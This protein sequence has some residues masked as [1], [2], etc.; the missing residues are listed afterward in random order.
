MAEVANACG[1]AGDAAGI[2]EIKGVLITFAAA[3]V[4]DAGDTSVGKDGGAIRE[5]EE[6][7]G[8]GDRAFGVRPGFGDGECAAGDTIHLTRTSAEEARSGVFAD[9]TDADG[10]AVEGAADWFEESS[11]GEVRGGGRRTGGV[12]ERR[13]DCEGAVG[14]LDENAAGDGAEFEGGIGEG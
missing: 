11:D 1:E 7:I 9:A 8:E 13:T 3:G 4:N 10:V 2:A 14:L 5:W 12:N 6:G